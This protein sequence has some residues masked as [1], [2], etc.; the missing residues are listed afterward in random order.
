MGD[1]PELPEYITEE[2][3]PDWMT[4]EYL[5]HQVWAAQERERAEQIRNDILAAAIQRDSVAVSKYG[6]SINNDGKHRISFTLTLKGHPF[7]NDADC[8]EDSEAGGSDQ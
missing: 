3:R 8:T 5:R 4:D 7:E 2:N 6:V 1:E